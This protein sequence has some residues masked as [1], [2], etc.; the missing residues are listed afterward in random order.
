MRKLYLFST[1]LLGLLGV[2]S[3]SAQTGVDIV[4]SDSSFTPPSYTIC[5]GESFTVWTGSYFPTMPT[6]GGTGQ[7]DIDWGDGSTTSQA[8]NFSGSPGQVAYTPNIF[9]HTYA[10][11]SY[12]ATFIY[13]D[14]AGNDDTVIW[15]VSASPYCGMVYTNVM[16]DQDGNGTG[17]LIISNAQLDLTDGASNTTTH[18]LV[19]NG[20][21][22]VDVTNDP[23]TVTVN[24]SWLAANNYVNVQPPNQTLNFGTGSF[25]QLPSFVVQCDPN[26]PASQVDLAIDYFYGWGFRAGL[27]TGYITIKVCNYTCSGSQTANLAITFDPLLSMYSNNLPG[28]T[29]TGNTINANISAAGCQV[30]TVYFTVPGA[31]AA[32]TPLS[33]SANVSPIGTTDFNL[34]NNSVTLSSQVQNSWDPNDK[35]VNRPAIVSPNQLDEFTYLVRFQNLGN[36]EAFNIVVKDTLDSD[37]DLSTFSLLE[38]SHSGSVNV[39]PA[40]RIATFNFIDINLPSASQNEPASHGY[41]IYKI[42]ENAGLSVGTEIKNTAYIYFDFNPPVITNTT[43]NVNQLSGVDEAGLSQFAAFPVPAS[44]YL[45]VSSKNNAALGSVTLVDVTGK[46]VF[47]ATTSQATYTIDVKTLANGVYSLVLQNDGGSY[48]QKVIVGK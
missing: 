25:F 10:A 26:A 3:A 48:N 30:F 17:D 41:A 1:L 2:M 32:G 37:L 4:F 20:I 44:D 46:T 35:S 22:G 13:S 27:S 34:A 23:Y 42:K 18:T 36:A 14:V 33:F 40:T 43:V 19:G 24:P 11:G 47:A 8:I 38:L 5:S 6:S 12:V 28:A 39:D 16:L 7:I 45:V 15:N 31:A 21:T 29:V 9:P